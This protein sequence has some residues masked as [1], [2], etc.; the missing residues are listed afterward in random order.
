MKYLLKINL[1]RKDFVMTTGIEPV[2][3][4]IEIVG[5]YEVELVAGISLEQLVQDGSYANWDREITQEENYFDGYPVRQSRA[6]TAT[7]IRLNFRVGNKR[8]I[9]SLL[10]KR[11]RPLSGREL[12][13]FKLSQFNLAENIE[14]QAKLRNPIVAL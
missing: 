1:N 14:R 7:L 4:N 10:R 13:H 5:T 12:M 3:P 6:R 11:L 9:E 8:V 2:L